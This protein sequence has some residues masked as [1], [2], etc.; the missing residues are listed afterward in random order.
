VI[1]SEQVNLQSGQLAITI[2]LPLTAWK[3]WKLVK[4]KNC[5]V[6]GSV[7]IV[8]YTFVRPLQLKEVIKLP[9]FFRTDF[10]TE[11]A[12]LASVITNHNAHPKKIMIIFLG[13][14]QGSISKFSS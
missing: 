4:R 5:N 8:Q 1:F 14:N 7:F 9:S 12:L 10:T 2:F 6:T 3:L 13:F 11:D